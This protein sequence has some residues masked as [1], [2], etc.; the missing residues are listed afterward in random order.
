MKS[1]T[2]Q[3]S[4]RRFLATTGAAALGGVALNLVGNLPQAAAATIVS[5][6]DTSLSTYDKPVL[7]VDGAPFFHSGIQFRYEKHKITYGWTDAQLEPV[8]KMVSEDGFTVVN[9]S[10]WWSQVEPSKG[11]FDWT[12][13]NRYID[14]CKKY[15]L[16]LE[17]LWFGTDS[18]GSS[19]G[20]GPRLPTYVTT[21]YQWVV[22]STGTRVTNDGKSLLDKTDPNL[23]AREQYVLGQVMAH[24]AAYDTTHVLVGV[25]ILNE[26]NVSSVWGKQPGR[27][28]ST[29]STQLWNDGGYTSEAQFRNDVLLNYLTELGRV[30]KQS[31]HSVWTRCNVIGDAK[32]VAENEALRQ[33]GKAHLDFFGGDPYTQ[34]QDTIYNY[35]LTSIF[36]QGKN[37]R[38]IMETFAGA[39]L[40]DVL[41]FN[42]IAGDSVFNMYAAVD[43]DSST[44]SS[45]YGLYDFDPATKVVTRK[46]VSSR[47]AALN[48]LLN[49]F[50]RDLATRSTVEGGGSTLQTFNRKATAGVDITKALD[51]LNIGFATTSGAQG[52]AARRGPAEFV[53]AATAQATFTLP[54]TIGVVRSVETGHYD[55]TDKWVKSGVKAYS[56]VSGGV[57]V[58]LAA[59]ECVRV[60]YLVSGATYKIKNLSTGR[61]LDTDL[62]G[63]VT[64]VAASVYDDQDWIVAK[65]SSGSWTIKNARTGRFYLETGSSDNSVVWN[66]GTVSDSSLWTMEGV[67]GGGIR[68]RN[69]HTGRAYLYGASTN[70]VKWNTGAQD[71]NT[72]WDFQPK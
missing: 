36:A 17:L 63:V 41:K 54:G 7:M 65:D 39:A 70:E 5:H 71:S 32:P 44:G 38:M 45:N 46:A 56:T 31:E 49:K 9:M 64:L 72:V 40:S 8:L 27:S 23:L 1:E 37:L 62:N 18:G 4:R 61:Y 66:S 35:G 43:P 10:I 14:L 67:A 2:G 60:S 11:A 3:W 48:R 69:T 6:V 20:Q 53:L 57:A 13:L 22:D 21:D 33:Q 51:G 19:V 34:N 12:E 47:V 16:K 58:T 29:Y 68:V 25:Q 42:G 24:I 59:G 26:P 50:H 28:Y 55:G 30:V 15:G 52:F